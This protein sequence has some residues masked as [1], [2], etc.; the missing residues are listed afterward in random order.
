[1]A[2]F[3]ELAYL[4]AAVLFIVGLKR[5]ASPATARNGN[6]LSAVG[7]LIAIVATLFYQGILRFEYIIAGMI[8]WSFPAAIILPENVTPPMRVLA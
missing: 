6:F 4:V 3:I 1:M 5:L 2:D 7:M 8:S